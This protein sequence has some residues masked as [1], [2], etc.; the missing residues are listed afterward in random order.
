[1]KNKLSQFMVSAGSEPLLLSQ[2]TTKATT[3]TN[4]SSFRDRDLPCRLLCSEALYLRVGSHF[5]SIAMI[6]TWFY[7]R[8]TTFS[9]ST[10]SLPL[11]KKVCIDDAFNLLYS[12]CSY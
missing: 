7:L 1:M 12:I 5:M 3:T 2:T 9:Y 8:K 10:R 6:H 11:A 4:S